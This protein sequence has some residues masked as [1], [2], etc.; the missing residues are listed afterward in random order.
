MKVIG[1]ALYG[2]QIFHLDGPQSDKDYKV[3]VV[4]EFID[5]YKNKDKFGLPIGYDPE[6]F[7]PMDF[8]KFDSSIR[9]GNINTVELLFSPELDIYDEA[10]MPYIKLAR[11]A[12]AEG[13]LAQVWPYFLASAKG[14]TMNS[15]KRY[16]FSEDARRKAASRGFWTI[17]FLSYAIKNG[18]K[19]VDYM[20]NCPMIYDYPRK[21]RYEED[22]FTPITEEEWLEMFEYLEIMAINNPP[23]VYSFILQDY[24][25]RLM[26][27]AQ[28]IIASSIK[29]ELEDRW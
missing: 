1:K 27:C 21:I 4:P 17:N 8:R 7:V 14:R 18:F 29:K 28:N 25:N 20:Y 26:L 13:Y 3:L 15:V 24:E 5:M 11:E 10:F 6:H 2:S 12:F 22:A 19:I 9:K 23:T 16:N